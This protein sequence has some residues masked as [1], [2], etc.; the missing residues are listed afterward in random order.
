VSIPGEK[1]LTTVVAPVEPGV[2]PPGTQDR[3][4]DLRTPEGSIS[5]LGYRPELDGIRA[6]AIILVLLAHAFDWPKGSFIG[7]D[8]F[9]ALSGFLITTILLE[10]WQVYGSISLRHF[11]LRRY[12]RLFPALAALTVVYALYV[13]LFVNTDVWMRVRG[14]GFGLTYM[15]NWAQAFHWRF[16]DTE[17]GYLWTL[18]IEEQFY[19]L[20]P[21]LLIFLLGR[22][23]GL[24]GT[25]WTLLGL[26]GAVVLWRIFLLSHGGNQDRTYFGTDTRFDELLVGCLAGT[27]FVSRR[28][29]KGG[30]RWLM[31]AT[32]GAGLFLGYR[33]FKRNPWT[34][35]TVRTTLTLVA[36]ATVVVIYG[37]VTG[38]FPLLK[39][40]LSAKWLV[41]VG[42]ISYSLYLWHVPADVLMR[43][44]A[45]LKSW[46]LAAAEFPLT[47]AAACV[48][49]YLV[50]QPFLKR[51]RAHQRLRE[52][53]ADLEHHP[54][55][56]GRGAGVRIPRAEPA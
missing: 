31:V 38:S 47:F 28:P 12:Y 22:G 3:I 53:K 43:E 5:R 7:V 15:A 17:I 48:S 21:A 19:L 54:G 42:A 49:Y 52:T 39:R 35:W 16:P 50:E 45:G 13:L 2:P 24:K 55:E 18:G 37:C 9:F 20:W 29:E 26:I 34:F 33:V 11:Y 56:L 6:I 41:F 1:G 30:S 51:K 46:Q 8:M 32:V 10:E 27:L 36:V 14:A 40:M 4:V 23:L 25:R 44:V